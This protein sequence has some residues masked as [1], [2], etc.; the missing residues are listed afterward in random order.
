MHW[1][2]QQFKDTI[3]RRIGYSSSMWTGDYATWA[4]AEKACTGYDAAPI[5]A[6]CKAAL[7]KIQ[8]GEA[9]YERDSMLFHTPDYSWALLTTILKTAMANGGKVHILDFGGALGSVYH[10]N[11]PF[12]DTI[13]FKEFS[14][15]V[16]EQPNFVECGKT[17]AETDILKFYNTIEEATKN[18]PPTIIL[19]SGV[20]SYLAQ[21]HVWI[22]QF[23]ALNPLFI[24]VDRVPF[25]DLNRDV[26]TVQNVFKSLYD[27]SYPCWFFDEKKFK[28]SFESYHL[29]AEF[30]PYDDVIWLNGHKNTWKG[31][32][33]SRNTE[34]W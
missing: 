9:R 12:L 5:L 14:W 32:I 27:G 28:A 8:A 13:D 7:L 29:T 15:H 30:T 2:W 21:P 22:E 20:M 4:D 18:T 25:L 26:I 6:K 33:F 31:L 17:H 16:V 23:T 34:G 11:K 3:K 24:L 19:A 10:Q 1:R